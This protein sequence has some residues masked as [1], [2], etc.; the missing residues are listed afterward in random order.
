[1]KRMI[2]LLILVAML[3]TSALA[4]GL[5]SHLPV[6]SVFGASRSAYISDSGYSLQKTSVGDANALK[7]SGVEIESYTMDAYFV[8]GTKLKTHEGLSK[9]AYILVD[10]GKRTKE[11][12]GQCKSALVEAMRREVG[13]PQSDS[14]SV[15]KWSLT[16]R[17][18]DIGIG[19]FKNYTGNDKTTVAVIIK[20]TLQSIPAGKNIDSNKANVSSKEKN[21][22]RFMFNPPD[23]ASELSTF[24]AGLYTIKGLEY[25]VGSSGD[26]VRGIQQLLANAGYLGTGDIDGTFGGKTQSALS[27]FQSQYKISNTGRADLATQCMLVYRN[28]SIVKKESCYIAQSANYAVVIWPMKGFYIGTINGNGGF[29]DGT[30]YYVT[31]GYYAGSFKNNLRSGQGKAH[32]SN[33]DVYVGA[34][35]KDMMNGKGKYYFGG[36]NAYTYYEGEMSN[37][38]MTGKGTYYA[39]GTPITGNWNRNKH[40][41]WF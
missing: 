28:A 25:E 31:G 30:Y 10:G 13:Q 23:R 24:V 32:F 5:G 16:D 6:S 36:E 20:S 26:A 38:T 12:L 11:Q 34:W 9:I 41:G 7:L 4:D 2:G 22:R 3:L 17:E 1:M 37:N 19:K 29:S 40:T 18:V 14:S 39:N 21:M 8:F 27:S 33:G 15:T 35:D